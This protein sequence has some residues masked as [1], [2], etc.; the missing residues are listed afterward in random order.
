VRS[1]KFRVTVIEPSI[2]IHSFT[3][4]FRRAVNVERILFREAAG[5]LGA[6]RIE[7]A[8][9]VAGRCAGRP[10]ERPRCEQHAAPGELCHVFEMIG[11]M[12]HQP[13][14]SGPASAV[15]VTT[16][17]LFRS[18]RLVSCCRRSGRDTVIADPVDVVGIGTGAD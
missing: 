17:S 12:R 11:E 13:V 9:S 4:N 6:R 18:I 14:R 2:S 10:H 15:I 5:F 1:A 7:Y 16:N 8:Q 3:S